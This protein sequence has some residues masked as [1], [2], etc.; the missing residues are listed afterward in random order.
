GPAAAWPPAAC[1]PPLRFGVGVALGLVSA[2]RHPNDLALFL[3]R[4]QEL[5]RPRLVDLQLLRDLGGRHE[6]GLHSG[7]DVSSAGALEVSPR[8]LSHAP[9][10][11]GGARGWARRWMSRWGVAQGENAT[12]GAEDRAGAFEAVLVLGKGKQ[13]VGC[14][15]DLLLGWHHARNV[16]INRA[17]VQRHQAR[18]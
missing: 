15:R 5:R 16:L 1:S 13:H 17:K 3:S 11:L 18:R 7:H 2:L 10:G 14:G 9:A 4:S 12:S 8:R 6:P